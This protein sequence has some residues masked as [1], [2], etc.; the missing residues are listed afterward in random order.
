[1]ANSYTT[2]FF[3][4]SNGDITTHNPKELVG[5][6]GEINILS[7]EIQ[8]EGITTSETTTSTDT[9][10]NSS[11]TATNPTGDTAEVSIPDTPSGYDFDFHRASGSVTN[12]A[13]IPADVSATLEWPNGDK[14][15]KGIV[16][17][18]PP[19]S[20]IS[21]LDNKGVNLSGQIASLS[22]D[23]LGVADDKMDIEL[24]VNTYGEKTTFDTTFFQTEYPR[25]TRDVSAD[26]YEVLNDDELS[27]WVTLSGL[28]PDEEEFYHDI[29]GSG[30]ARFRFR[31]DWQQAYPDAVSQLRVYDAGA[32]VIH[33]VALAD[34]ADTQLD[35]DHVR[36]SEG[37]TTYAVDVVD[38]SET[39]ALSW[40]KIQTHKGVV[41]P[42][43]FDQVSV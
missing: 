36:V 15:E 23:V 1:M 34:P 6:S 22:A 24:E 14:V 10:V 27:N 8:W 12:G 43:A 29:D 5:A 19:G 40:F 3:R 31:F 30:E 2:Q 25:V 41:S 17:D 4:V 18:L 33:K 32:D 37:G 9:E 39:D 26:S 21:F 13:D 28:E 42:R 38:P 11:P 20:S 16:D 7:A 35:Y